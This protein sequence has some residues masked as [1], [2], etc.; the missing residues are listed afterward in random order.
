MPSLSTRLTALEAKVKQAQASKQSST[1]W[2]YIVATILGIVISITAALLMRKLNTRNTEL[3]KL[4]TQI[5]QDAITVAQKKFEAKLAQTQ[6]KKAALTLTARVLESQVTK[7]Q[8]RLAKEEQKHLEQVE[9]IQDAKN[10]DQLN[11]TLPR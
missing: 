6:Q 2:G 7:L 10:W 1:P 5:E 3:A 11:S 9:R 4:R 8:E